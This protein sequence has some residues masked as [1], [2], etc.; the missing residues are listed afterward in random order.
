MSK[1][2]GHNQR[3]DVSNQALSIARAIDRTCRTPGRYSIT[4]DIPPHR[5]HPW[6]IQFSRSEPL[7]HIPQPPR[8]T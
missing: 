3:H 4:I 2:S 8:K 7:Q 6:R 1:K 5:S